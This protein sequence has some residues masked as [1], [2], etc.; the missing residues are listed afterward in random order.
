MDE[1]PN[2]GCARR[3]A[4]GPAGR[5]AVTGPATRRNLSGNARNLVRVTKGRN[6]LISSGAAKAM[7]L[8][9]PYDVANL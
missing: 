8:R 5:P 3:E 4:G 9:G 7:E 6:L 2:A 1:N